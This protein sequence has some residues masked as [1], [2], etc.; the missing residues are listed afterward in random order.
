[1]LSIEF[2]GAG[3]IGKTHFLKEFSGTC[4]SDNKWDTHL[5][6]LRKINRVEPGLQKLIQRIIQKITGKSFS[7]NK[8]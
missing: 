8:R 4:G 5:N 2:I 6:V 3:C 7:K 1:M